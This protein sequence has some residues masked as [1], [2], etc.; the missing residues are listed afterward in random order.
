MVII[1]ILAIINVVLAQKMVLFDRYSKLIYSFEEV[2]KEAYSNSYQCLNFSSDLQK[3]LKD[4]GISSQISIVD[5]GERANELHAVVSI[6]I[7]PQ[8]GKVVDYKSVDTCTNKEGG[9]VCEKGV[10]KNKNIYVAN[11]IEKE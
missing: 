11:K 5:Q 7:E 1:A 9:L 10:I 3:K 4:R 8:T 2:R 6:L